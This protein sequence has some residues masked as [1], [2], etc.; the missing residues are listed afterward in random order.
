MEIGQAYAGRTYYDALG[1][2]QDTV[3]IEEDGWANF[4]VAERSVSVWVL[5]D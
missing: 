3:Q 1:N 4:P 2:H 5:A